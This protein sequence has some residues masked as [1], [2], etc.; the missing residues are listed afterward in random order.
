MRLFKFKRNFNCQYP[1]HLNA[2]QRKLSR[3]TENETKRVPCCKRSIALITETAQSS[4]LNNL[5]K[6]NLTL[7]PHPSQINRYIPARPG[8]GVEIRPTLNM[9]NYTGEFQGEGVCFTCIMHSSIDYDGGRPLR[10][11]GGFLPLHWWCLADRSNTLI[12]RPNLRDIKFFFHQDCAS[13]A[14]LVFIVFFITVYRMLIYVWY[15][16]GRISTKRV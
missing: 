7:L 16:R 12:F 10:Y 5:A 4:W 11:W 15:T 13:Y 14:L 9:H 2:N 3:R 6:V 1:L 8:Q